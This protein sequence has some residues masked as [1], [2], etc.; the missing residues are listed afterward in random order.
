MVNSKNR[1]LLTL[2]AGFV[3]P[4]AS[5]A[6][7]VPPRVQERQSITMEVLTTGYTAHDLGE[8][9]KGITF[10]GTRARPGVAAVDPKVIP[11]GALLWVPGYGLARAEDTGGAVQGKHVDLFFL[12][13][14]DA[15]AWG[16]RTETVII[17]RSGNGKDQ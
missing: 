17:L 5:A 11:L 7:A 12:D 8:D 6:P 13:R 15:L 14:K 4:S 3:F 1:L 9:G 10:T 16:R 2:P